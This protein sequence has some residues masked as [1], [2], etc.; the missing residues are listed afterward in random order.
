MAISLA[1]QG[2]KLSLSDVNMEGLEETSIISKSHIPIER[3]IVATVNSDKN[4]NIL[5][6]DV[7][8][9]DSVTQAGQLAR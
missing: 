8:D 4:V 1:K 2:S 6:C 9:K 5:K 3:M 7:S